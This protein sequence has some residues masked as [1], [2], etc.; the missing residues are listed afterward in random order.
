MMIQSKKSILRGMAAT[1]LMAS[2]SFGPAALAADEDLT[3]SL[4]VG[5]DY[6]TGEYG[7][8]ESTD[9]SFVP[10]TAQFESGPWTLKV[11]GSWLSIDGPGSLIADGEV[12]AGANTSESGVGD[13]NVS[14]AYLI[15]PWFEGGPFFELTGKIKVPTA[16]ETKGLGTGE[17]D[18]TGM[19]SIYQ[20]ISD[21]TLFADA[22]YRVRGSSDLYELEDGFV[23]SVGASLKFSP[24]VSAGLMY[25]YRQAAT[26]TGDDPMD[27]MPYITFKPSEFWSIN[28]YGTFG[29][30]DSSPDSGV[31]ISLKRIFAF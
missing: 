25:N 20:V 5:Y 13:T 1:A 12:V 4:S 18:Y 14:V 19:V 6:S 17:V 10:V 28:A 23:G 2:L 7:G 24:E 16:D 27:V 29:L 3:L 26:A 22:G 31:G 30:S 8:S 15:Y 11:V 21:L 9:M